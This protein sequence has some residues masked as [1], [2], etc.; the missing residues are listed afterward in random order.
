MHVT[1][2]ELERVVD[3]G[4]FIVPSY[5]PVGVYSSEFKCVPLDST[6]ARLHNITD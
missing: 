3:Y 6:W 5:I 1:L 4:V 2:N